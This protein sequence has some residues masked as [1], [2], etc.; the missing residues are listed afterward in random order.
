MQ[1]FLEGFF[2]RILF[3]FGSIGTAVQAL[4]SLRRPVRNLPN[5]QHLA[6]ML[7]LLALGFRFLETGA[8]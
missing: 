6:I 1:G 2:S 4:F 3:S 7:D 5:Q 8:V